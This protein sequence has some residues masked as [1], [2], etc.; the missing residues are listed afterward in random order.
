MQPKKI[1]R[2]KPCDVCLSPY[3]REIEAA[4]KHGQSQF[5]VASR[6]QK[7]FNCGLM[8]LRAKLSRH[9]VKHLG[10]FTNLIQVP[11]SGMSRTSIEALAQGLLDIGIRIVNENPDKVTMRDVIASQKLIFD[12]RRVQ[13]SEDSFKLAMARFFGGFIK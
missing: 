2:V 3:R 13:L 1:S 4:I 7:Y 8:T 5:S 11:E 9:K 12:A 10:K 6:Y